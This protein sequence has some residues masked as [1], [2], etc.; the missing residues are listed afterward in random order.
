MV[1]VLP[2]QAT[3]AAASR[4]SN[5]D[6]KASFNRRLFVG[7]NSRKKAARIAPPMGVNQRGL[8]NRPSAVD[9]AAVTTVSVVV[10][11]D[12]VIEG[13]TSM[14]LAPVIVDGTAQLKLTVPLKLLMG[15][16]PTWVLPSW[17]GDV[18]MKEFGVATKPKLGAPIDTV[19][20]VTDEV[21]EA[22]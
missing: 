11:L 14:Q 4:T 3:M 17:P 6:P 16:R 20:V 9:G 10:E 2:P 18:I 8:L 15:V 22:K 1:L 12:G 21:D 19:T 7:R 5:S 13:E